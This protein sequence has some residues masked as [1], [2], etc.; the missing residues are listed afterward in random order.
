MLAADFLKYIE[1]Q[2]QL[3]PFLV[4]FF[5]YVMQIKIFEAIDNLQYQI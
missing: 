3:Y 5:L 4:G 1:I 2:T